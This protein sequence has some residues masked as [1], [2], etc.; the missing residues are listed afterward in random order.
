MQNRWSRQSP[1]EQQLRLEARVCLNYAQPSN[2]I[3]TCPVAVKSGS[4]SVTTKILAGGFSKNNLSWFTLSSS[5]I[6]NKG[7]YHLLALVDSGC[8]QNLSNL[9]K[10]R[11]ITTTNLPPPVCV[12]AL[13]RAGLGPKN[14]PGIFDHGG[15]P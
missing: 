3:A 1:E 9:L 11:G 5:I 6:L 4:L 15:P 12:S 10:D 14:S 7:S 8:K 2:F 13:D